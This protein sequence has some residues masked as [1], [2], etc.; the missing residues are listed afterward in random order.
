[1]ACTLLLCAAI[2]LLFCSDAHAATRTYDTLTAEELAHLGTLEDEY[3]TAVRDDAVKQVR[4]FFDVHTIMQT[5]IPQI[6]ILRQR[7]RD[8]LNE[9]TRYL[10][11]L[12]LEQEFIT[13]YITVL[14]EDV[15]D[16]ALDAMLKKTNG[17]RR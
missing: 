11:G 7:N 3:F 8:K 9:I 15:V 1:M 10:C 5:F 14:R 13:H 12:H 4:A 6:R 16:F 2:C 17:L